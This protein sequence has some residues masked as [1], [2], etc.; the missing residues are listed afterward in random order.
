MY[1]IAAET[2]GFPNHSWLVNSDLIISPNK[3]MLNALYLL[4]QVALFPREIG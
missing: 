1:C 2:F 3:N 4:D